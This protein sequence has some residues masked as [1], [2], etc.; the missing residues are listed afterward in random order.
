MTCTQQQSSPSGRIRAEFLAH[1]GVPRQWLDFVADSCVGGDLW[2]HHFFWEA[3]QLLDL[4][5][6]SGVR[7]LDGLR[8]LEPGCGRGI[9][10]CLLALLGADVVM[11]D[12]DSSVLQQARQTAQTLRV[13]ERTRHIQADLN[14]MPFAS[15]GFDLVWSA[16]VIEHFDDPAHILALM[17]AQA[18]PEGHVFTSVPAKWT[19]HTLFVRAYLRRKG[20]YE[21]FDRWGWERSYSER[22]LRRFM[23]RAGLRNVITSTCNLR[24]SYLDD[25]LV[26]PLLARPRLQR[27]G[28]PLFNLF[29]ALEVALPPLRRLAFLVGGI[30]IVGSTD[31]R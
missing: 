16:G 8:V 11:V 13:L 1:R 29:D 7:D 2:R 22:D 26:V 12:Y 10:G 31:S 9:T 19:P 14:R 28:P 17:A 20:L 18:R 6:K 5:E 4:L 21:Y 3:Y 25:H 27:F 24:R 23:E 30:G 15:A